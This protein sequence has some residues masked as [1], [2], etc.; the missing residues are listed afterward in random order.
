MLERKRIKHHLI[1]AEAITVL[2]CVLATHKC[3]ICSIL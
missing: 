2:K 1:F 3:D